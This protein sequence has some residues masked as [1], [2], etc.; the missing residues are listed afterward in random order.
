MRA[1]TALTTAVTVAALAAAT[2]A[3]AGWQIGATIVLHGD[4]RG[5]DGRTAYGREGP[6]FRYGFDRG[7]REGSEEGCRDG[8]KSRDP[9]YWR[10]SEFR[11]ADRGYRGWMGPRWEYANGFRE[12][13]RAGYRRAYAA[14][15]PDWRGRWERFGW[16]DSGRD[17]YGSGYGRDER[18]R[19]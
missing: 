9:R 11:H 15:R 10:E 7:W 8:R 2:E 13:Y 16:S 3:R 5:D 1:R 19:R 6:A 12:G 17:R 4:R 18:E 14:A